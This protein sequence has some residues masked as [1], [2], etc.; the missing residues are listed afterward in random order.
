MLKIKGRKSFPNYTSDFSLNYGMILG[1]EH[2]K[3]E[4]Q[5]GLSWS[6]WMVSFHLKYGNF[7]IPKLFVCNIS[8][9]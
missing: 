8:V 2:P 1:R 6:S 4:V 9:T 7:Q 5:P 3:A